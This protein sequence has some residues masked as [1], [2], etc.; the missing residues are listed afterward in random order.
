MFEKIKTIDRTTC[1]D[2]RN[3]L[4]RKYSKLLTRDLSTYARGR[5]R[6]WI[7]TEFPLSL[8][9]Q[10]FQPGVEDKRLWSWIE[11]L[12]ALSGYK[13]SP[14]SAL[15]IYGGVPISFHPDAP[16]AHHES[17]Q[18]NLGGTEFIIDEHPKWRRKGKIYIP[19]NPISHTLDMGEVAKF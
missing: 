11:K 14:E 13:N 5:K 19:S 17:L 8:Q 2:V 4:D 10:S 12:W 1:E 3:H 15:A 16:A 18:I 7:K 6:I 9:Y